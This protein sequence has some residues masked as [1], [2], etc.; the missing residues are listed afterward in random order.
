MTRGLGIVGAAFVVAL[1]LAPINA[2]A[3][4]IVACVN[5]NSGLVTIV[6]PNATCPNNSSRIA[7]NVAGPPGTAL[8]AS[9]FSCDIKGGNLLTDGGSL[10][11]NSGHFLVGS[12]FG[13]GI[14]Y[15]NGTTFLLQPGIYL[16]Q[17]SVP[18][19][20][21][22]YPS[23]QGGSTAVF[24][25]HLMVNGTDPG[26][27]DITGSNNTI[28]NSTGAFVAVNGNQLLNISGANTM[29]GFNVNFNTNQAVTSGGC[30]IIFTRLQ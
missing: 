13:S 3:Q 15:N 4:Q 26:L 24:I 18:D 12:S 16:L 19:V 21:L 9:A 2:Q 29:I 10:A 30:Q 28:P 5:N 27:L 8:G 22:T 11:G 6:A 20:F 17:L 1:G 25:L 7:W 23:S 14:S